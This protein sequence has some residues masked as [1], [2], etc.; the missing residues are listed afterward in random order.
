MLGWNQQGIEARGGDFSD[1]V[2]RIARRMRRTATCRQMFFLV[3]SIYDIKLGRDSADL[4]VCCEVLEHLENP[5]LGLTAEQFIDFVMPY[6]NV[7][8]TIQRKIFKNRKK[9]LTGFFTKKAKMKWQ[10]GLLLFEA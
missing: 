3:C 6:L 5:G 7:V 2:I 8:V 10:Q 4:I 1:K 9:D